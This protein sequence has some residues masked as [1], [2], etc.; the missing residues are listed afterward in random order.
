MKELLKSVAVESKVA[1]DGWSQ[2]SMQSQTGDCNLAQRNSPE[3]E[4]LI[5]VVQVDAF[6]LFQRP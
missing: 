2:D 5:L 6:D 4:A 1:A 3:V